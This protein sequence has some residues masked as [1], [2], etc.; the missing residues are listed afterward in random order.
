MDKKREDMERFEHYLREQEKSKSTI[1]K[2]MRDVRRFFDFVDAEEY[3]REQVIVY[4][5]YLQEHYKLSSVNSMLIAL[6]GFFRYIGRPEYCVKTCR[7]QRQIFWPDERMISRDE[8]LHLIQTAKKN[9][10]IRLSCILQ[11]IGSTGIRVSELKFITVEALEQQVI[12]I[13]LKGKNRIVPLPSSLVL[14]LKNYCNKNKIKRGVVFVTRNGT[15]VDRRN[16]WAEMKSLCKAAGIRSSKVFPHNLRHMFARSFYEKEKDLVRLADFLGH[17]S[18]ETTRRYTVISS[19]E[20]CLRQLE[21]GLVEKQKGS[22]NPV[23]DIMHI[24]S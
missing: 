8:Y 23:R 15:P 13:Q 14:L 1:E 6:N 21:L 24:M 2:Y 5:Q 11:A 16:I 19:M 3:G 22:E 9:G 18:V 20:A 17:N 10:Q 4:K 12:R 7:L